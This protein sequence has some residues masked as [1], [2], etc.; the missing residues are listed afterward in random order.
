[1]NK[2]NKKIKKFSTKK[3]EKAFGINEIIWIHNKK[4]N[5]LLSINEYYN[6]LT[7][8]YKSHFLLSSTS[9]ALQE[10]IKKVLEFDLIGAIQI[11]KNLK[12]KTIGNSNNNFYLFIFTDYKTLHVSISITPID[13]WHTFTS[14]KELKLFLIDAK[15]IYNPQEYN[16]SFK[17]NSRGFIGT[18]AML[19]LNVLDIERSLILN[20]FNEILAWGSFWKDYPFRDDIYNS[21]SQTMS[22]VDRNGYNIQAM[23]QEDQHYEISIR[24]LFSKS[25]INIENYDGAYIINLY[26]NPLKRSENIIKKINKDYDRQYPLDLPMDVIISI[27]TF[28]YQDHISILNMDE[29]TSGNLLISQLIANTINRQDELIKKLELMLKLNKNNKDYILMIDNTIKETTVNKYLNKL[30]ANSNFKQFMENINKNENEE[31][32]IIKIKNKIEDEL[33]ESSIEDLIKKDV[34]DDT[35]NIL[36]TQNK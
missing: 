5:N 25:I 36:Y 13:F 18:E 1:M 31:E 11:N 10:S 23:K 6:L 14:L 16:N 7:Q 28:L 29:V 2:S 32:S 19:D 33:S 17:K 9:N 3:L 27:H 24:T 22:L 26:Y 12:E 34:Y 4:N 20:K 30:L 35:V 8:T 21:A 15:N